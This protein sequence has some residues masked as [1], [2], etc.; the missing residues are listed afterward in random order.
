MKVY[1]VGQV[2]DDH[3]LNLSLEIIVNNQKVLTK[4][5][6]PAKVDSIIWKLADFGLQT[7]EPSGYNLVDANGNFYYL[8]QFL[9]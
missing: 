6:H 1:K 9:V 3:P 8:P 4:L 5:V 7:S 2:I